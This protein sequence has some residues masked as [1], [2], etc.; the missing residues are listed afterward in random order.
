MDYY[1]LLN[2]MTYFDIDFKILIRRV[3]KQ[4]DIDPIK[5]PV[6]QNNGE[7]EYLDIEKYSAYNG[8]I[9]LRV[10][11]FRI[12]SCPQKYGYAIGYRPRQTLDV[13]YGGNR[14]MMDKVLKKDSNIPYAVYGAGWGGHF[15]IVKQLF[16][17]DSKGDIQGISLRLAFEGCV[18]SGNVEITKFLVSK[19]FD[20]KTGNFL[21]SAFY[22]KHHDFIMYVIKNGGGHPQM[23]DEACF[24]GW[25]DTVELIL[26][27]YPNQFIL[28]KGFHSACAGKQQEIMQMLYEKGVSKCWCCEKQASEH[29]ISK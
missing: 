20:V 4:F 6:R 12:P 19:G 8:F 17:M 24:L 3:N 23:F 10:G 1:G 28:E 29:L 11:S 7:Y 27:M 9:G 14:L 13:F 21:M 5:I 22:D 15:G 18:A 26:E 2:I 25:K 16:K